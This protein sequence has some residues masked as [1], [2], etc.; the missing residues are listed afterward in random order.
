MCRKQNIDN[1]KLFIK[2]YPFRFVRQYY[3]RNICYRTDYGILQSYLSTLNWLV[4]LMSSNINV[5]WETF[6]T[7]FN[8]VVKYCTVPAIAPRKYIARKLRSYFLGKKRRLTFWKSRP[9]WRNGAR[10][11]VAAK[12]F[13]DII[14]ALKSQEEDALLK[15]STS[16]FFATL[17]LVYSLRTKLCSLIIKETLSA[18]KTVSVKSY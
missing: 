4:L 6:Q 9:P 5:V 12:Q 11:T 2:I 1:F 17:V 8:Q 7:T 3:H 16:K 18:M 10:Y 14:T 15:C 13:A